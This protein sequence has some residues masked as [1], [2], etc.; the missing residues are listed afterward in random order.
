MTPPVADGDRSRWRRR[1]RRGEALLLLGSLLLGLAALEGVFRVQ[2]AIAE[3]RSFAATLAT[4]RAPR[5]GAR[6]TL[7][8]MIRPS[9]NARVVYELWPGMEVVFDT[10]TGLRNAVRT[11]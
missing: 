5:A 8:Q 7:G 1:P 10:G 11:S 4:A 3:R 6:V 2:A 9:E